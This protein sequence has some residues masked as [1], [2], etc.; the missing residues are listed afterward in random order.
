[1]RPFIF[2]AR[3]SATML[4]PWR[5]PD[6]WWRSPTGERWAV[7][8]AAPFALLVFLMEYIE[9]RLTYSKEQREL[10]AYQRD[11]YRRQLDR[12]RELLEQAER[13]ARV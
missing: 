2:E 8:I 11:F 6:A 1:M 10:L 4:E 9:W 7:I 12:T 5:G 3:M 13:V